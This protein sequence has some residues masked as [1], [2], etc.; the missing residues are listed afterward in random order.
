MINKFYDLAA[1]Q[2]EVPATVR[3]HYELL[4]HT[5]SA[6]IGLPRLR[7]AMSLRRAGRGADAENRRTLRL[8]KIRRCRHGF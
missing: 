3:S 5:A 2:P 4:E 1:M 7:D 6:C 8:L